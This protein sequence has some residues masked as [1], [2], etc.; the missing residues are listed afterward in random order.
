[1]DYYPTIIELWSHTTKWLLLPARRILRG[2]QRGVSWWPTMSFLLASNHRAFKIKAIL[3]VWAP[4]VA[5]RKNFQFCFMPSAFSLKN[6]IQMI[7]CKKR[8][9]LWHQRYKAIKFYQYL[10]W[11]NPCLLLYCSVEDIGKV[12]DNDEPNTS[13][14]WIN[15]LLNLVQRKCFHL[16]Q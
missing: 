16:V 3:K 14:S 13:Y 9:A 6:I 10:T 7:F 4:H 15:Y 8:Q 12:K 5:F 11:G 2:T 1:M